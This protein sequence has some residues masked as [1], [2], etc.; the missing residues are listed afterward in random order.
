MNVEECRKLS[1]I[2]IRNCPSRNGYYTNR[3][4]KSP[5]NGSSLPDSS[6]SEHANRKRFSRRRRLSINGRDD[7]VRSAGFALGYGNG[8]WGLM[9]SCPLY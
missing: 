5:Y 3:H 4:T 9:V 6:A 1:D 7:S 2:A 8:C